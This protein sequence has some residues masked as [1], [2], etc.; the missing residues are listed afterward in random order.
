MRKQLVVAAVLTAL[1]PV[2]CQSGG[3]SGQGGQADYPSHPISL[4]VPFEPGASADVAARMWASYARTKLGT[5]VNVVNVSGASGITGMLQA[6][7]AKPDGYTLLVDASTT[8]SALYALRGNVPGSLDGRTYVMRLTSDPYFY[9]ACKGQSWTT[10]KQALAAIKSD[11]AHFA[12]GAG[13]QASN[14]M[15]AQLSLF[16]AAGVDVAKT[17]TVVFDDGNSPSLQACARGDVD[18]AAG[19]SKDVGTYQKTGRMKALA[20]TAAQPV[21]GY[22][23]IPT[24]ASLGYP[25][26][27]WQT[28]YGVSGPPK[29]PAA[30]I[31][32]WTDAFD[33][34]DSDPAAQQ[35]ASN[36]GHSWA[37][38]DSSDFTQ[39][40]DKQYHDLQQLAKDTGLKF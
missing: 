24:T 9:F 35:A 27:N 17:R 39:Y 4:I 36:I 25:T 15:L 26:A 16:Q 30:V 33:N 32:A 40:V 11:P 6:I 22:E 34:V 28:W 5:S 38:M 37:V 29:L 20:T 18:F 7:G 23:D 21:K 19:S 13:A 10:L 1:L 31:K 2:A 12:W 8:S 14:P 3:G